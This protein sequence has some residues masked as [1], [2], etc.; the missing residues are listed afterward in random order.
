MSLWSWELNIAVKL[1]IRMAVILRLILTLGK[2][3]VF[4]VLN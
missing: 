1:L 4:L 3:K 2:G